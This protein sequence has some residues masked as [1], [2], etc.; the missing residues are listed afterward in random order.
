MPNLSNLGVGAH[1]PV[2]SLIR[3]TRPSHAHAGLYRASCNPGS[4]VSTVQLAAI[5]ETLVKTLTGFQRSP[6]YL[7]MRLGVKVKSQMQ[8]LPILLHVDRTV[9]VVVVLVVVIRLGTSVVERRPVHI[10][11]TA[12]RSRLLPRRRGIL[13]CFLCGSVLWLRLYFGFGLGGCGCCLS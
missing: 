3:L 9:V 5:E 6:A 13:W 4:L 11:V 2:K 1:V 10:G 12:T 7:V 8:N